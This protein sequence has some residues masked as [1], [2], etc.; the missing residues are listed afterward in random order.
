L[1]AFGAALATSRRARDGLARAAG[2]AL[3][4][5]GRGGE[6]GEAAG[7]VSRALVSGWLCSWRVARRA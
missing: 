2:A 6:A 1:A 3:G 5:R 4:L 7:S